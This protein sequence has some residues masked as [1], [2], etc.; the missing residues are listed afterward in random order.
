MAT[1]R[2][3]PPEGRREGTRTALHCLSD[4]H[5]QGT[6]MAMKVVRQARLELSGGST[7]DLLRPPEGD[8]RPPDLCAAN[9]WPLPGPEGRWLRRDGV[10]DIPRGAPLA[11]ALR[12]GASPAERDGGGAPGVRRA[13]DRWLCG[14]PNRASRDGRRHTHADRTGRLC[15]HLRTRVR[16]QMRGHWGMSMCTAKRD[17]IR[18]EKS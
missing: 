5:N 6:E 16:P 1:P 7:P 15:A 2:P 18:T 14:P 3:P 11:R 17:H 12:S 4:T 10:C 8:H 9:A 13:G